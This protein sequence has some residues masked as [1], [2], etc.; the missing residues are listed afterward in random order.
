MAEDRTG[1]LGYITAVTSSEGDGMIYS[2]AVSPGS[3]RRGIGKALMSAELNHLSLK[4]AAQVHLQVS[5]NNAPAIALYKTFS[6][7]EVG[8]IKKYYSNGDDA[9][10]MS[11][12]L[13]PPTHQ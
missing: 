1:L 7:N 3:R 10:V 5:V 2:I 13:K 9:L 6:F 8:R 12:N 4:D 11:L